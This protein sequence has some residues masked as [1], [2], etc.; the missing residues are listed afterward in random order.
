VINVRSA[1]SIKRKL[2]VVGM[3]VTLVLLLFVKSNF[4][5]NAALSTEYQKYVHNYSDWTYI[6]KPMFPVMINESQIPIGQNWTIVCPLEAN[7]SYHV[8]CYG[9]WIDK[10]S[11]PKTDYD[12][13]VYNPNNELEGYHTASAGIPEQLGTTFDEPY[14]VPKY[15]GNYT[16]IIANDPRESAA[17]QQATFMIIQNIQCNTWHKHYTEGKDGNSTLFDTAWAYEFITESQHVEVLIKVP[18]TLDIYEARLYLMVDPR[19]ASVVNDIPLAWEPGLY[20]NK[21]GVIGGYNLNNEGYRGVA[22]ASCEH[23]GQGML[24]NFTSP[25][26]G[27][28]LYHLVIIGE[29]GEAEVSLLI[30]TVFDACLQPSIVP[31]KVYLDSNATIEYFSKS[32]TLLNATLQY[33]TDNWETTQST[34]MDILNN[35]KTCRAIVPAQAAGTLVNYRVRAIDVLDNVLIA[36]GSYSVRYPSTTY[37]KKP[38]FP[39][40]FMEDQIEIGRDWTIVCP[41]E[42]N[43]SYHVYCYGEWIEK[44]FEPKTDYDIYVYNPDNELEGYHTASAG[45]PEHLGTTFDTPFFVPKHSGNYTFIIAND[46]RESAAAQPATFMIIQNI[47]CNTWHEHYVEGKNSSD[48]HAFYTSWAYE[49]V[50]NS[51]RVE[52]QIKVPDTLDMYE[53]RLYL[54]ADPRTASVVNDIPLAWELGLYGNKSGTIGGYN[55]NSEGYRGVAYASCEHFGQDMLINFTSPYAGKCLYHLVLI[56]EEGEGTVDFLIKTAFDACLQPL[57]VLGKICLSTDVVVAYVSKSTD[58]LNATLQYSED[59][60]RSISSNIVMNITDHSRVCRAIIP[61]HEA[62]TTVCYR[63]KAFDVLSNVLS[64]NG[65]YYVSFVQS[66]SNW[67]YIEKPM[68][69]VMLSQS[70]IPI[71]QN[72]TIICPLEANL[73]Y[74]VYCYGKWIEKGSEPKTDYDIYV[75]NPNGELEGYHTASAGMLENLGSAVDAA[76]FVPR[77]SGNYTFIIVNDARES[78]AAQQATFM[79]IQN[80]QCNTWYEHYM[81]AKNESWSISKNCWAYEFVSDSKRLEIW[82]KVPDNLDVY[83]VRLYLMADPK[84]A[85]VVNGV[86]LA[87]EAG[88]YGNKSSVIGGYDP[89]KGVYRGIAYASCEN[90]G[91]DMLINFTALYTGK[92]LYHLVLISEKGNGTLRFLI[93]TIFDAGLQASIIP[94]KIYSNEN[95]TVAYTSKSTDLLNATLQY[96]TDNWKNTT[97]VVME[98]LGN[99][100]C[101]AVIPKQSAGVL[102]SYIV[103]A[104]DVLEN[105]LVAK[106]SY[107][108][109]SPSLLNMSLTYEAIVIGGNITVS[110]YLTPEADHTLIMLYFNSANQ[111][112]YI[113]CYT[114]ED[115]SFT[116]SFRPSMTGI[117]TVQ[118]RFSGD[119]SRYDSS[120]QR[121]SF[122]VEEP[123]FLAKYG[124]YMVI[125]ACVAVAAIVGIV[126][127]RKKWRKQVSEEW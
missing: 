118:A 97:N 52:V 122:S 17:A 38:L 80:I 55:L 121:L 62:G 53:A 74:H 76:F 123:T 70:Q 89:E 28:N 127:Y 22:Y 94:N 36:N 69:P 107:S 42:A 44:G 111:S 18:D 39:V 105:V 66:H 125:G 108:V 117:W 21:S 19:T 31:G 90:F 82:V 11:E 64:A 95:T 40:L 29:E 9:K 65:S 71:G 46:P 20:G 124:L 3:I 27:K 30:K 110:G 84:T 92:N 47:Q 56:G 91:Q 85:T 67:T 57:S 86:P 87:W 61:G 100:T 7:L 75:Y 102:V 5:V 58:L 23:F 98:I 2:T 79:I 73:S 35:N 4:I 15:S 103:K 49:F 99:R 16:F 115:G 25:Y 8:Y 43:L 101:R 37:L 68:F 34:E 14:F 104:T 106:G 120:S 24:I 116:G 88:L 48:L 112:Q 41:L 96:S 50:S 45:V 10:G 113:A 83:E 32:T 59:S 119:A 1:L 26:T 109:K 93:K 126:V 33:S 72:W 60:W 114:A 78:A 63:I 51:Q 12:I 77:Y 6:E 13:Y 54:M 81:N